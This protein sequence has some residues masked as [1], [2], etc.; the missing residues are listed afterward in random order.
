[1]AERVVARLALEVQVAVEMA[2]RECLQ[3]LEPKIL[4]QA[5]VAALVLGELLVVQAAL[6]L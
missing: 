6:A 2:E 4:A 5:A 1:M 3:R